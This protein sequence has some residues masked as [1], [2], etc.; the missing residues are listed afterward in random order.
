[1]TESQ[2]ARLPKLMSIGRDP[3]QHVLSALWRMSQALAPDDIWDEAVRTLVV[4]T[5]ARV[6]CFEANTRELLTPVPGKT[7]PA[8]ERAL[9]QEITESS[10]R[11]WFRDGEPAVRAMADARVLI[12]DCTDSQGLRG[13][14]AL[15]FEHARI[16]RD[17]SSLLLSSIATGVGQA[18]GRLTMQATTVPLIR[19]NAEL[20]RNRVE[21]S[22]ALHDGPAQ[23]LAMASM[24]IEQLLKSG[25]RG[26]AG[27]GDVASEFLERAILG[28]RKFISELRGED[29]PFSKSTQK[30]APT[31][32][33]LLPDDP[34]EQAMLAIARE[35]LRNVRKHAE[36]DAVTMTIRRNTDG[37]EVRVS[38]NGRGFDANREPGHF[39][40]TQMSETAADLG[41]SLSIQSIPGE[42]T[43]VRLV[44][45]AQE[46][47]QPKTLSS[48]NRSSRQVEKRNV[49]H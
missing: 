25:A 8:I 43:T 46:H 47:A 32:V 42:G 28:L 17:S 33:S 29:M 40:L 15:V 11:A 13:A 41:G 31:L 19:H 23:D 34:Q 21:M 39:G 20:E 1:M 45:P 24:A 22:R 12:A 26:G 27:N 35:A 7:D 38:D 36:A 37:I 5:D 10:E 30:A 9:L 44:A 14:I 3:A 2:R 49:D 6:A 48:D 4:T 16:G 18:L